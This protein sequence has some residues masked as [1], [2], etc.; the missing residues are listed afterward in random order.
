MLYLRKI[1]QR[2]FSHNINH[3]ISNA[4]YLFYRDA[5]HCI[6]IDLYIVNYQLSIINYQLSIEIYFSVNLLKFFS[7]RPSHLHLSVVPN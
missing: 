2:K 1:S 6:P 4:Y 7:I 3:C 5:M